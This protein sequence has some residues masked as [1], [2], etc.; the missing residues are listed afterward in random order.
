M[1][2][3]QRA[4][5]GVLGNRG[6]RIALALLGLFPAFHPVIQAQAASTFGPI[7]EENSPSVY[8]TDLPRFWTGPKLPDSHT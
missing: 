2:G 6:Y 4:G 8:S 1:K 3:R 5:D 7:V